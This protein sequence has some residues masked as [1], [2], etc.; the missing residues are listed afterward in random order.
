MTTFLPPM[1]KGNIKTLSKIEKFV[2]RPADFKLSTVDYLNRN[3]LVKKTIATN[4]T[5][6]FLGENYCLPSYDDHYFDPNF[7]S[8]RHILCHTANNS[9]SRWTC[10]LRGGSVINLQKVAQKTEKQA[11]KKETQK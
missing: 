5:S 11:E 1:A 8:T 4:V 2:T 7:N 9:T 3:T 6:D 10:G